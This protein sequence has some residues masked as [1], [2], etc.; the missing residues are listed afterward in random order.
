MVGEKNYCKGEK[1]GVHIIPPLAK[2]VH[3]FPPI[4]LKYTKLQKKGLKN[5]NFK[6]NAH[7]WDLVLKWLPITLN[8]FPSVSV[9]VF[10]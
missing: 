4:D 7:P 10:Y 2:S 6:F 8:T 5:I 1:G 3:V 9:G